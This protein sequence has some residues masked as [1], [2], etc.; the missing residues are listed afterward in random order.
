MSAPSV[1]PSHVTGPGHVTAPKSDFPVRVETAAAL[2]H[3]PVRVPNG[4]NNGAGPSTARHN[5][6]PRPSRPA[7]AA[8]HRPQPTPAVTP[9]PGKLRVGT[10]NAQSLVPKV[11]E[12]IHLLQKEEL[13]TL[14][15][16]ETWLHLDILTRFMVFPGF[17]I[18]RLDRPPPPSASGKRI[19][20][21]GVA[22]I[23]KQDIQHKDTGDVG[24]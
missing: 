20:G 12:I 3:G 7:S 11:D 8:T 9:G 18:V 5:R 24:R 21:G 13:D 15:V 2:H 19:R 23:L 14:C 4:G 16:C 10:V 6:L 1:V 17:K 22:I